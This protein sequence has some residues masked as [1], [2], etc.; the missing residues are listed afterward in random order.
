MN[1]K[2]F[3]T[4]I[5]ESKGKL[6]NT[7]QEIAKEVPISIVALMLENILQEVN[8]LTQ[9]QVKQEKEK[10]EQVQQAKSELVEYVPDNQ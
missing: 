5:L 4:L 8:T 6:F 2:G 3:N 7:V 1:D 9:Q 10:Y